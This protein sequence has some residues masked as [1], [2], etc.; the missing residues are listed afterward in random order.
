MLRF[1]FEDIR[2]CLGFYSRLP[3]R[4]DGDTPIFPDFSRV[5]WAAPA[6]GAVIGALAAAFLLFFA[7]L[8]LPNPVVAVLTLG[9][10]VAT[11]GA[12]HEDGLA[13]LA[14]GFGGGVTRDRKLAIM[15][16]SR[17][18]SFGAI[19][20]TF[21][22]LL[23]VAAILGA[24]SHGALAAALALVAASALS[25]VVGLLPLAMLPPARTDGA[26]AS[27][28]RP[29]HDAMRLAIFVGVFL[30][31]LPMLTGSSL[32]QTAA[33]ILVAFGG[34]L[35]VTRLADRQI[36]GYTGDVLGAAQQVAEIGA[37]VCLSA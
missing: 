21:S 6:A 34:G 25:R 4:Q 19:A 13:D 28:S 23:R 20:L 3:I 15:R 5:S 2:I 12:L 32:A 36:G 9:V 24:L 37:L 18:G 17:V 30:G 8:G 26:G 35:G 33:A 31:C 22:V 11:T 10:L 14:D 7:A 27:V 29:T 16:D 1:V